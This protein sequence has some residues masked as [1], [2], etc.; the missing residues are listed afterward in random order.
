ME[1]VSRKNENISENMKKISEQVTPSLVLY[2]IL[3]EIELIVFRV[4]LVANGNIRN[5]T[6][7]VCLDIKNQDTSPW[8]ST[9]SIFQLPPYKIPLHKSN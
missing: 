6:R 2:T 3:V 9:L 1:E 5:F 4:L 8:D 7:H